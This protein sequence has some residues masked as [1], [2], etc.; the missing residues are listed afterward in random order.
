[1]DHSWKSRSRLEQGIAT[2]AHPYGKEKN[3]TNADIWSEHHFE[4]N[5]LTSLKNTLQHHWLTIRQNAN[6]AEKAIYSK[7]LVVAHQRI[8]E[9]NSITL[10]FYRSYYL[11]KQICQACQQIIFSISAIFIT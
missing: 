5:A 9:Y 6:K 7:E 1:M 4:R 8:E 11:C 2:Y 3:Q 10:H